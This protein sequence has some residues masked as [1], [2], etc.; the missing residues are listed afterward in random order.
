VFYHSN[1][2]LCDAL[3]FRELEWLVYHIILFTL[4]TPSNALTY[5]KLEWFAYHFIV[6]TS[7]TRGIPT[8][9]S[10]TNQCGAY[11]G[12]PKLGK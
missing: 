4:C 10:T 11:S 2:E 12:L 8:Y 3:T 5:T 6:H 7:N 1:S 9:E